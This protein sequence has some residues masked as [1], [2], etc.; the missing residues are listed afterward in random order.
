M[1]FKWGLATLLGLLA[2]GSCTRESEAGHPLADRVARLAPFQAPESSVQAFASAATSVA[3]LGN[4]VSINSA[5]VPAER[6]VFLFI[7]SSADWNAICRADHTVCELRANCSAL[8]GEKTIACDM[9]FLAGRSIASNISL[10][11]DDRPRA[12]AEW[13]IGHE[14]GHLAMGDTGAFASV[15]E[16]LAPTPA[17]KDRQR[18]EYR[19]DCY[20]LSLI[21][22]ASPHHLV[23]LEQLALDLINEAIV[24]RTGKTPPVGVGILFDYPHDVHY[25][26]LSGEQ[27][28]EILMRSVRILDIE[29]KWQQDAG[30]QAMLE[31]FM[32]RL[33]PDPLW[34]DSTVCPNGPGGTF[35][36]PMA[37]AVPGR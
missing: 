23:A 30:T 9:D 27:H 28:P 26:F 3:G 4:A 5:L 13:C 15:R 37:R 2:V 36:E 24:R 17:N 21:S 18:L 32:R 8:P 25:D 22:R 34:S 7:A 1:T 11:N 31:P 33:T 12:F 16:R 10:A 20:A 19:A 14:I 6:L 29:A 35:L